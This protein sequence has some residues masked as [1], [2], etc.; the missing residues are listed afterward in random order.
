VSI[1]HESDYSFDLTYSPDE[2]GWYAE[3]WVLATGQDA[4]TTAV[5]AR[6]DA[7]LQEART[8]CRTNPR[9]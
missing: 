4:H 7:A 2:G 5:Y 3:V 6:R 1:Y 8:W 9:Q